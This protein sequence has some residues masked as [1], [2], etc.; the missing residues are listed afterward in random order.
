M[1]G[2]KIPRIMTF[3]ILRGWFLVGILI[4][5]LAFFPNGLD[6]WSARGGLFV[7]MAECSI[8]KYHVLRTHA[9]FL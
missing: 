4:D 3:D 8:Q 6:W 2:R 1:P 5:H 9:R 7:S